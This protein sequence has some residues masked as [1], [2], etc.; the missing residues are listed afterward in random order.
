MSSQTKTKVAQADVVFRLVG[1]S[2]EGTVSL[3]DLTVRMLTLMGLDIGTFQTFPAEIKGGS[4][5][6]QIRARSGPVLSE[7]DAVDVL[8]ALN[9]EGFDLFGAGLREDGILLYDS[10]VFT[11]TPAPGRTDYALAIST[12]ARAEKDAVRHEVEPE[13]LKRLPAPKNMV[14]LGALLRL[15]NAPLEPAEEYIRDLFGRKGEAIVRMNISALHTG[16]AQVAGQIGERRTPRLTPVA[17]RDEVITVNGNQMLCMGALAAGLRFYAGYPIT[18]ASEIMEFF[19]KE[20][21]RFQGNVVQAEDEMAA[22]GMCLGASYAGVKAMTASSGPGISLM[23]EQINLAGQAELPVVIVDVQRGGAST[24]MPTKTSQGDLNLALYGV[25]NESPRIV[26]AASSV[27]DC[28]WTAV[29]AFNLAEAYQCPVLL[30]SEQSLATRKSTLPPPDLSRAV[31]TDRLLASVEQRE[32]GY[33]RYEDTPTGV[34][35]MALPGM[36]KG[37]Y[38]STGIEHDEAGDPGYTPQL[39]RRMKEKRFRKLER[40]R[41]ERAGEFVRV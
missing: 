39:A 28:F 16:A 11:P 6:Y 23:V 38:V 25:H 4:V 13:Q 37:G 18:P 36:A 32:A 26:L 24:G 34:S 35:P 40:L 8:V 7:G 17:R 21:P 20:L 19:A 31:V 33:R 22:L 30:L 2:G 1:E 29:E 3:G 12:L 9:D 15:V 14:G 27:E 5:M 41:D 10:D